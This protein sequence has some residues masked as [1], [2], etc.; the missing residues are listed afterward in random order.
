MKQELKDICC[1]NLDRLDRLQQEIK[2]VW[3]PR[4]SLELCCN[5]IKSMPRRLY[6][7]HH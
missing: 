2:G 1:P 5:L 6:F 7:E 4:T 3:H